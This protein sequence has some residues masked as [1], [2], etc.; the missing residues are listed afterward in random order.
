MIKNIGYFLL[1]EDDKDLL[2]IV[3]YRHILYLLKRLKNRKFNY[4]KLK[5]W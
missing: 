4:F 1:T 5:K 3:M 2:A